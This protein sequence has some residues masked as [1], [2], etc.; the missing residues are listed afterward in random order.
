MT[1]NKLLEKIEALPA[2]A[3]DQ[4][5]VPPPEL[6]GCCV[7]LAR[8]A[9]RWKVATLADF[10]GVSI[11]TVERLERGDKISSENVERIGLALGYPSGYFTAPRMPLSP[12]DAIQQLHDHYGH[13]VSV[14]IRPLNTQS[15]IRALASCHAYLPFR[16]TLDAAHD[17]DVSTFLEWMDLAS[18]VLSDNTEGGSDKGKR[19]LL[20]LR[21]LD[22][23]EQLNRK[24]I[25]A[26]G[27]VLGA[28]CPAFP[29][30]KVAFLILTN[31][32]I[33]PGVT[34]RHTILVDERIA[35]FSN[36]TF[37]AD[38]DQ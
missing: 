26:S 22:F 23:V 29:D 15:Q 5:V 16:P 34:K 38:W 13:L 19:R 12:D 1:L 33:D 30:W 9:Q 35:E 31:K 20:Y 7:F 21:I 36:A 17:D 6:I 24:G 2:R 8:T 3:Q 4:L 10:A 11:S 28:P 37:W 32:K 14:E 18:F 25:F 27:G